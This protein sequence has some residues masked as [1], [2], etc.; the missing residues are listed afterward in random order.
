[1]SPI[2]FK[3]AYRLDEYLSFLSD[4]APIFKEIRARKKVG[5]SVACKKVRWYERVGLVLVGTLAY[6]Y[7][8]NKVGDCVFDI[9]EHQIKRTSKLGVICLPWTDVVAIRRLSRAYLIEKSR[10]AMPLPYRCLTVEQA[11][12]LDELVRRKEATLGH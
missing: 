9:D 6:F 8:I 4:Y 5:S 1:M 7:K 2:S 10:G 12:T 3:V 11:A